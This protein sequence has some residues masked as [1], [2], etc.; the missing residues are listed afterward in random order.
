MSAGDYSARTGSKNGRDEGI[1][2]LFS[3]KT[4]RN[5][6]FSHSIILSVIALVFFILFLSTTL[7]KSGI[8]KARDIIQQRNH[9]VSFFIDG[10][11]S[12]IN[13]SVEL[14][15]QNEDVQNAPNLGN[16]AKQ[17]VLSLYM[18]HQT[19]NKNISYIYSGYENKE[20]LINNYDPPVGYDPRVRPWYLAAV[21][22]SPALS[23]GVPY[24][25]V[26]SKEWLLST[27][28]VLLGKNG[29]L[30]GVISGESFIE[31]ITDKLQQ[32]DDTYKSSYSYVVKPDGEII[33]HQNKDKLRK[34][35]ANVIG[36]P[37]DLVNTAEGAF[38]YRFETAKKMAHFRHCI[39]A[40]WIVITVVEKDEITSAIIAQIILYSIVTGSIVVLLGFCQSVFLSKRLSTPLIQLQKKVKAINAGHWD[41]D[42]DYIYPENEIGT[43]SREILQLAADEHYSRSQELQKANTLLEQRNSELQRLSTTDQL[44]GLFNRHKIDIDLKNECLRS[45]RYSK[46]LSLIMFDVDWF[47][48]V[49]DN[50]GHPAGDSVLRDIAMVLKTNLRTIDIAGRWGGEEFAIICPDTALSDAQVLADRIRA[51]VADYS[52]S[53]KQSVTISVG[54]VQFSGNENPDNLFRRADANLYLAKEGG[55][56]KVVAS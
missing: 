35:I 23:T 41:K 24:Q 11:F 31:V 1:M 30:N 45:A 10:Y 44:T 28:K 9:A 27:S 40:D 8:N 29:Q 50:Y 43:I 34:N 42:S 3:N 47:K 56:N 22:A 17:R 13:N 51:M 37:V 32:N 38:E 33:L 15:S 14:L 48:K 26:K 16:D 54:V 4:I 19:V 39:E 21:K 36:Q 49:N 12:E 46:D 18:D 55:K 2:N 53:I 20:F 6:I 25:E 7:Y 52:F 5:E